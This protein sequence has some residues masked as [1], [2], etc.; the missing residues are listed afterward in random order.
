[1]PLKYALQQ[2]PDPQPQVFGDEQP[3]PEV[4][5]RDLAGQLLANIPL[6]I[7]K[8]Y[9]DRAPFAFGALDLEVYLL[10]VVVR[11]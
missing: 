10:G 9:L 11:V 8:A 2:I 1:M 6:V 4:T 5:A 7:A 3:Q